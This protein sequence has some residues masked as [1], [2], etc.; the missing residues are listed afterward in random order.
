LQSSSQEYTFQQ[1]YIGKSFY[2][3][4]VLRP[5]ELRDAYLID[6]TGTIAEAA[7]QTPRSPLTIPLGTPITI[8][9]LVD[10]HVMA[11]V[12]G[13]SLP[14]RIMVHTKL[15]TLDTLAEELS[16]ILTESA[17]LQSA[18]LPMRP[19]ITRQEVTLGMSRREVFMS[20][21]QPDKLISVPGASGFL[22]EW[23]YFD[24][25][26]HLYLH[27]GFVTNWQQY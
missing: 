11:R 2:T 20:W 23:I 7:A 5:Y 18:R 6:L 13:Y 12:D 26:M 1:R 17:P 8:T 27:N 25:Q 14:F 15:G 10:E 4:M 9:A 16:L 3:A 24:R 22:E 21:G 19:F